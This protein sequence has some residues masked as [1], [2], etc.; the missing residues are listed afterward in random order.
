MP[1][2]APALLERRV[3]PIRRNVEQR[4]QHKGPLMGERM[5]QDERPRPRLPEGGAPPAPMPDQAPII[6][7][8]EIEGS[9]PPGSAAAAA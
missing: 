3:A 7:D 2:L 5:R 9:R 1:E 4:L 6:H 8:I